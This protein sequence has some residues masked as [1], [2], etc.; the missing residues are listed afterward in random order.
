MQ[1]DDFYS[2]AHLFVAAVR[3]WEH[4]NSAPPSVEDVCRI[5]SFSLERSNFIC[6]QLQDLGI[7]EVVEG[8]YGRRLCIKNH[9][10]I[11]DIPKGEK[12]SKMEEEL[13][14]FKE[15]QKEFTQ[16]IESIQAKQ[17]QKKKDLFAE[18]EKKLKQ[19]IDK[20]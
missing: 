11:E 3:I 19:E 8:A 7:V 1:T 14:K 4:Q 13:S 16:K 12:G 18:V 10:N 6:K 20:K 17:A 5:L 15:T 2:T 9:L